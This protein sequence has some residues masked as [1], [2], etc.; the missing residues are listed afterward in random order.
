MLKWSFKREAYWMLWLS[1][2]LPLLAVATVLGR[3]LAQ[4][5]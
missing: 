1:L 4:L 2:P 5:F 3:W